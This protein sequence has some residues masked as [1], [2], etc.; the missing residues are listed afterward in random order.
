MDLIFWQMFRQKAANVIRYG[1]FLQVAPRP[2]VPMILVG[3]VNKNLESD[4]KVKAE[5]SEKGSSSHSQ[6]LPSHLLTT[7]SSLCLPM[8]LPVSSPFRPPDLYVMNGRIPGK[9]LANGSLSSSL[10]LRSYV[11]FCWKT[12]QAGRE[13]S[14]THSL[15]KLQKSG[16]K[17]EKP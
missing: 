6:P 17:S 16:L 5:R 3:L 2:W 14:R 8:S 7:T 15:K 9:L 1:L 13:E 4:V 12:K 11:T 10:T